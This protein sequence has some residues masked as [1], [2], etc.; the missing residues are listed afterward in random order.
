MGEDRDK[1]DKGKWNC[2]NFYILVYTILSLVSDIKQKWASSC[3]HHQTLDSD[4]I[5]RFD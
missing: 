3:R 2:T 1:S 4:L 5:Q